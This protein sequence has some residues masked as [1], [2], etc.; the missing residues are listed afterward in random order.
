MS[1]Q[2]PDGER[3]PPPPATPLDG[4]LAEPDA[5]TARVPIGESPAPA[6]A[7]NVAAPLTPPPATPG[8]ISAEPVG[9]VAA[10]Q[11]P[12][13]AT[14]ATPPPGPTVYWE[15]PV[16]HTAVPVAD[17]VVV[18]GIFARA[19]AYAVDALLLGAINLIVF[20]LLGVLDGT[21]D[22][23]LTLIVSGVLVGVDF[24]YFVG[25]WTSGL[26]ATLGMRLLR[27]RVLGAKTAGTLSVNDALLRW[28]AL[29]GAVGILT[30]VPGLGGSIGLVSLLWFLVLLLSAA[31]NPL[32][33]GLHDRW[34]RSVVVQ[35]APGG[36]GAALIT[37]LVLVVFVGLIL[38]IAFLAIAGDQI[39]TLLTQIGASV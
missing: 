17:G 11:D 39:R 7:E 31:T 16:P 1:S 25:L 21:G 9:W 3:P 10:G 20:G 24:L 37:C 8:I 33:Q 27:L 34:A 23:A 2:T 35:P 30:L 36:S 19:V 38:P 6:P 13:G 32:R 18:A 22:E 14:P 12:A 15:V 4:V 28:I 5:E 26:H 29:S